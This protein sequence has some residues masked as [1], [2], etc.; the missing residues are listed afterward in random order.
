MK[1]RLFTNLILSFLVLG[2]LGCAEDEEA[3]RSGAARVVQES[4]GSGERTI[5]PG[6]R[7]IE[8]YAATYASKDL[9]GFLSLH[10]ADAQSALYPDDV[11]A[12]SLEA[13]RPSIVDDFARRPQSRLTLTQLY[14]VAPDRWVAFGQSINGP[15]IAPIMMVFD[16]DK[17]AHKIVAL[18]TLIGSRPFLTGPSEP[19]PAMAARWQT[20][21]TALQAGQIPADRDIFAD[22]VQLFAYPPK[23]SQALVPLVTGPGD[24]AGVLA[25]KWGEGAFSRDGTAREDVVI[26]SFMQMIVAAIPGREAV[27]AD[28]RVALFTFGTDED[29]DSFEKVIRVDILG[30][31]GG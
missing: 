30:P 5:L 21:L 9:A 1:R 14:H 18:W 10:T 17:E 8:A 12:T 13:A 15:Q 24:V 3:S 27:E 4:K 28:D 2:L 26:S 19:S 29:A 11:V 6:E 22:E 31:S 16:L 7:L 25:V 23:I 20:L